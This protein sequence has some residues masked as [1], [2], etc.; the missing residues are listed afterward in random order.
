MM[1]RLLVCTALAVLTARAAPAAADARLLDGPLRAESLAGAP[2]RLL[3]L[4]L[5]SSAGAAAQPPGL[6]FDLLGEAPPP[7]P[8]D[9]GRMRTR[10]LML[11]THQAMGLGLLA[12]QLGT[13]TVG[14]LNYGDKF[15]NGGNTNRYSTL[16]SDLAWMNAGLFAVAGGLALFA[17]SPPGGKQAGFDRVTLHKLSMFVAAAGMAAQ[18][19][20]GVYTASRE[21]FQNQQSYG[22]VHLAL[23]YATMAALLTGVAA[24]VL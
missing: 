3:G 18:A 4:S 5:A 14:Q 12:V 9:A 8:S 13:T 2:V 6:D 10:R 21:G 17:P 15:G 23:G 24:I 1:R 20:L 19:G 16:H 22:K 11:K 7:A